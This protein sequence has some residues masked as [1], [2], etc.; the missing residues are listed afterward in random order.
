MEN[1][2]YTGTPINER[3]YSQAELGRALRK[4]VKY[5]KCMDE[6]G[7]STFWMAEHHFQPEG[8]ELIPNLLPL[9]RAAF[10]RAATAHPGCP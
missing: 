1:L 10:G 5:A 7:Y 6:R 8:T 4:V 9:D 3:R 2:G